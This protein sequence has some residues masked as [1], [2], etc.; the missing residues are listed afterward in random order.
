MV[1]DTVFV[2]HFFHPHLGVKIFFGKEGTTEKEGI[3]FEVGSRQL[4]IFVLMVEE[5]S[6]ESLSGF[7]MFFLVTKKNSI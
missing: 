7:S 5:N 4:C 6:M 1:I 3:N 2:Y